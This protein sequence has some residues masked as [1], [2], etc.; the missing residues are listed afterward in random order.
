MS[1]LD[2]FNAPNPKD[3]A[4]MA[5]WS[6]ANQAHHIDIRRVLFEQTGLTYDQ[7][8]LDPFDP[9]EIDRWVYWHQNMHESQNALLGIQGY[10]LT[11]VDFEDPDGL[12]DWVYNHANEHYQA[13]QI[14]G[15]G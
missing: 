3:P 9:K 5:I 4:S 13:G 8:I 6:F 10:D 15:L 1:V 2:L 14:L 7:F 12:K 11:G